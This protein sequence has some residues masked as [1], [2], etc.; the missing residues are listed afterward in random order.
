MCKENVWNL[1]EKRIR[2][3]LYIKIYNIKISSLYLEYTL[4]Y[5]RIQINLVLVS[6]ILHNLRR[7]TAFLPTNQ[8]LGVPFHKNERWTLATSI[9]KR[10]EN[11]SFFYSWTIW[12]F[13][14]FL[15]DLKKS[16]YYWTCERFFQTN[17]EKKTKVLYIPNEWFYWTIVLWETQ[18]NWWMEI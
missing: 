8:F 3:F 7:R 2:L 11:D 1:S 14:N 10:N 12:N 17:F 5:T 18:W 9:V 13:F 16:F 6:S 4:E 15:K